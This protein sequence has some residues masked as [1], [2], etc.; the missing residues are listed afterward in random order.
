MKR[1]KYHFWLNFKIK[2]TEREMQ[3]VSIS[4]SENKAKQNVKSCFGNGIRIE[5]IEI[6]K[7]EL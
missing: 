6:I 4:V 7:T 2:G 1:I 5:F 3:I